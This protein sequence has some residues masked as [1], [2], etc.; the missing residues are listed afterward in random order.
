MCLNSAAVVQVCAWN[1]NTGKYQSYESNEHCQTAKTPPS[2]MKAWSVDHIKIYNGSY[3][4]LRANLAG[5]ITKFRLFA[6]APSEESDNPPTKSGRTTR[7]KF[8]SCKHCLE[9]SLQKRVFGM[10]RR[11]VWYKFYRF[12]Q[13][14]SLVFS[15]YSLL[16]L[17]SCYVPPKV[18]LPDHT[19]STENT[20]T[21]VTMNLPLSLSLTHTHTDNSKLALRTQPTVG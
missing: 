9:N 2:E 7:R 13:S 19:A 5:L 10:R 8:A 17:K 11:K 18:E 3:V 15:V 12:W 14:F 16:T 6:T 21:A 1:W 4:T 20:V